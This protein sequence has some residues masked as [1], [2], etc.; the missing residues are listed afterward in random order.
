MVADTGVTGK[1]SIMDIA[2]VSVAEQQKCSS[3]G[4]SPT[5]N[6]NQYTE[7]F[8]YK[9]HQVSDKLVFGTRGQ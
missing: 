3:F 6:E 9:I 1:A 4:E 7:E 5:V 2:P 8:L